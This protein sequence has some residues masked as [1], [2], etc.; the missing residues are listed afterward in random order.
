MTLI[1]IREAA[2]PDY[3]AII[4]LMKN[5]HMNHTDGSKIAISSVQSVLLFISAKTLRAL[6]LTHKPL[7]LKENS[8]F[9]PVGSR[10]SS[11]VGAPQ[12]SSPPTPI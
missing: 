9:V 2:E 11:W 4:M 6:T 10:Y 8:S 3:H 7:K 12:L 1:H 5:E